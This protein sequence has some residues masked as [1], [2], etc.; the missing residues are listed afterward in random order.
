MTWA[1]VGEG[2]TPTMTLNPWERLAG[3]AGELMVTTQPE[4]EQVYVLRE[5]AGS[6]H[7]PHGPCQGARY[8]FT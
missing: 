8:D 5:C 3:A 1:Q 2:A 6:P 4:R 7:T